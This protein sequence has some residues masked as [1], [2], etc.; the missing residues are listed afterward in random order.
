MQHH[1]TEDVYDPFCGSGTSLIAA[2][3]VGRRC[4]AMEIEPGYVQIAID[5][6][7]AFTGQKGTLIDSRRRRRRRGMPA[8]GRMSGQAHG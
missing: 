3:Q 5:R 6:W 1:Q 2:E 7:E 8:E 4:F